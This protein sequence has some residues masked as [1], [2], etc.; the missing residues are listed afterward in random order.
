MICFERLKLYLVRRELRL[1][2]NISVRT[3][4]YLYLSRNVAANQKAQGSLWRS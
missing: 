1:E 3:L 4:S 2:K